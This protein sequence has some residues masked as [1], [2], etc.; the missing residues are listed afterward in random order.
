[1]NR[2]LVVG[3]SHAPNSA[4]AVTASRCAATHAPGLA[5]R[6]R[7]LAGLEPTT[8][9]SRRTRWKSC[10]AYAQR[11]RREARSDPPPRAARS[12]AASGVEGPGARSAW[13]ARARPGAL[14]RERQGA[15]LG[16]TAIRFAL[17]SADAEHA[18]GSEV[19]SKF[20]EISDVCRVDDVSTLGRGGHDDCVDRCRAF[21]SG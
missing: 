1:M 19:T 21:R 13:K 11:P 10:D 2:G 12:G 3:S 16:S 17:G 18:Y 4:G 20:R 7:P 5:R 14:R 9:P 8:S 6:V 15:A